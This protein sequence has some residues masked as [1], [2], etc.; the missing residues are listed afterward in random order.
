MDAGDQLSHVAVE[1]MYLTLTDAA[2]NLCEM[3]QNSLTAKITSQQAASA[4]STADQSTNLP[5]T[6]GEQRLT[7]DPFR[8]VST[9]Q[10][11][12]FTPCT[13]LRVQ[14]YQ[15]SLVHAS[16]GLIMCTPCSSSRA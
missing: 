12:T 8:L 3:P 1:S 5:V 15:L 16:H 13:V 11:G 14:H 4:V 2:G 7:I 6:Q 9:E 10:G